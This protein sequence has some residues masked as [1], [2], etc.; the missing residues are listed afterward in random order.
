MEEKV[1]A[2]YLQFDKQRKALD[3]KNADAQ[4]LEELKQLEQKISSKKN[5]NR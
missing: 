1:E 5:L 4:D 2:V 3:A